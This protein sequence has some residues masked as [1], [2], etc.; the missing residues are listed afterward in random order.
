MSVHALLGLD[1]PLELMSPSDLA[2]DEEERDGDVGD[3]ADHRAE[4]GDS[5][6]VSV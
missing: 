5:L 3:E 1:L 4:D 2:R 6:V